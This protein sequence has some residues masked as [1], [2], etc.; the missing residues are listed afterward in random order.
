[1]KHADCRQQGQVCPFRMSKMSN[2]SSKNKISQCA[3]VLSL[4]VILHVKNVCVQNKKGYKRTMYTSFLW[5]SFINN[6]PPGKQKQIICIVEATDS[7]RMK[8]EEMETYVSLVV[9]IPHQKH[10]LFLL[11]LH[12]IL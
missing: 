4:V 9:K 1:M 12:W 7:F 6:L 5:L 3:C 10:F 8:K 2:I 11:F